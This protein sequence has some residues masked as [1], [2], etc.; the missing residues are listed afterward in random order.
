M[1]RPIYQAFQALRDGPEW[2]QLSAAQKRIVE[3]E[4]RDF[5]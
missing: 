5:K 2:G 4:L 3:N 1:H